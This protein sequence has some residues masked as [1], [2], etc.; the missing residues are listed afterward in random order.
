M[1]R[2]L[3]IAALLLAAGCSQQEASPPPANDTS[4]AA[5]ETAAKPEVPALEGQ[6]KVAAVDGKPIGADTT[7]SFDGGRL[8]VSSGCV[9]RG[10]TYT[11]KGNV[12]SFA[13]DPGGSA[14]CGGGPSGDQEAA[15]AALT[16]ANMVI[17]NKDGKEAGLSGTGGTLTFE[18]R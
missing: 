10:W 5:T 11:Q 17:F 7:A 3:T 16:K 18:R 1:R 14:N 12:V 6:W 8:V 9:R 2:T 15:Y 4:N 13:A